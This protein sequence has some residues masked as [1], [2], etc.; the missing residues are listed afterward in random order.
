MPS[1][2][3]W[4]HGAIDYVVAH[5]LFFGTSATTFEP[6]TKLSRA[7]IVKILYTLEGE[8][9]VTGENPFRDVA[10]NRWYTNAVIWAAENKIVAGIGDGKFDPDG[11]AN[12][13]AGRKDPV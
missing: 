7:M 4:S 13:R 12:A 11:D 1:T 8:P 5:K 9:A 3:Y 6:M 10:D 2:D